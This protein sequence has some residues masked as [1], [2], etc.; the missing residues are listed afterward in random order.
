ME[1]VGVDYHKKWSYMVIMNERGM[2]IKEGKVPS[3][4][5]AVK[6]FLAKSNGVVRTGVLEASR[7]WQIMHD[8]LEAE[9][10]EVKLAHPLLVDLSNQV[11]SNPYSRLGSRGS[12]TMMC[13]LQRTP[14]GEWSEYPNL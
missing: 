10:D 6:R 13:V 9:L 7:N 14:I 1:Y 2:V 12:N 8:W 5:N 11:R 4:E 3:S